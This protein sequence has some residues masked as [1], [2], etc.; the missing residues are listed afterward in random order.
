MSFVEKRVRTISNMQAVL[1]EYEDTSSGARHVHLATDDAEMVFLVAFPTVPHKS[2]GRAH[3]LEHLALCG[4]AR[5]PVRDPFFSMLRRS[6]ATFMNAMTY[7]DR[8]VYPFASTDPAD[9]NNLLGIYLDAAFFP[10][11]DYLDFLQ[12]GWRYT[13][14][15]GKLGYGGVVFNEMKGAFADPTRALMADMSASLFKGTTYEV[16]SGGDPL[17]IPSLTHADLKT[18]H[19]THYHP[20]QAVFMTSGRVDPIAVQRVI[21]ERVL[22]KLPGKAP[23][24]MPELAQLWNAPKET[25]ICVPSPTAQE[26][27]HGVQFAWMLGEAADPVAYCHAH[28]LECGLVGDSSAPVT[29]AMESAGYGR[30]SELNGFDSSYR[31]MLFHIGMEGLTRKQ[32]VSAKKLIRDALEAAADKGVPQAALEA[33]LRD[34]R[35]A[36]REVKGGGMPNGLRKLLQALPLE[37]AGSDVMPGFDSEETLA[38]LD[39]Q[40]RDP[41]FFKSLV[42]N[43]LDL[44]T[45]LCVDVEPDAQYFDKR[46][47]TEEERLRAQQA[48][49]SQEEFERI[50]AESAALLARQRQPQNN[51]VLPRV[52]PEDVSPLP[53]PLYPLPA[54][55][56]KALALAIASN[57]ISYT[58]VV[59]DVSAFAEEDWP[60]LDLYTTLLPDVGAGERS[61]EEASA[62]RQE[63]VPMFD[64]DLEAED[65]FSEQGGRGVLHARVVFS[66]RSLREQQEAMAEVISESIRRPRFDEHERIAFLIDSV[67]E[68]LAQEV[69][70]HGDQY[71]RLAA[72]APY[73]QR[74]RFENSIEGTGA[75][76]FYSE[77]A[78]QIKSEEGLKAICERLAALHERVITCPVQVICC[79]VGDDANALAG[80]IDVPGAAASAPSMHRIPDRG[81]NQAAANLALLA[82]AQVNHCFASWAVPSIG[83]A[84]VPILSVLANVLTNQ[85][86]HQALRE[87]GGA[88]GALATCSAHTGIFTMM[89]YRDPRLA[90]TY[91]D[92]ARAIEW[93]IES[94]LSR[95]HVEEAIIGVIGDLDKPLSPFDEAMHAWRMKQ[96]G[97][98]QAMREQFRRGVLQC[99][100][101]DLKA[102]ARKYLRGVNPSRA[103]FAGNAQQDLAGLAVL[104]LLELVA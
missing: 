90:A 91:Q 83:H 70:D 88:Y 59:Y 99:T 42:R 66:A 25:T 47:R 78:S 27:E 54:Q 21:A 55:Q 71:A 100:E 45:R 1:K 48:S 75:L 34:L 77:L 98:D 93:V 81:S 79:G 82:P 12:E 97:I 18:F 41:A 68:D 19:A 5:Y 85:V 89:S 26:D 33:A 73:S 7:A 76:R 87:E 9:F 80:L 102:A 38:Q 10:R 95:E 3:I 65:R 24:R 29:R 64:V 94:P 31:Q 69:G 49:M 96:R 40:V 22:A 14:E 92:F 103:A 84:D 43:L 53:R 35:F 86:L 8:T 20:S 6:T 23:R 16:E 63:L 17:E 11:L 13:L 39:Q 52:R 4:S 101:A 46:D 37:M 36:Q 72:E 104:D 32:T 28:L 15:N 57:G 56:G 67:A 51:D 50:A 44:P 60:W 74:R 61:Y 2:D 58:N 30:P 62:W